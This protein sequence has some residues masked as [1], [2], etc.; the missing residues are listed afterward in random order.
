MFEFGINLLTVSVAFDVVLLVVGLGNVTLY[1][2]LTPDKDQSFAEIRSSERDYRSIVWPG[3]AALLTGLLI[4]LSSAFIFENLTSGDSSRFPTGELLFLAACITFALLL[5][6]V[7]KGEPRL[8][9][10]AQYP[11]RILAAAKGVSGDERDVAAIVETLQNR[12]ADW[13]RRCGAFSMGWTNITASPT[14]N[15]ALADVPGVSTLPLR[16][17]FRAIRRRGALRAALRTAPWRFGWPLYALLAAHLGAAVCL[18]ASDADTAPTVRLLL[19]IAAASAGCLFAAATGR[20]L[21]GTRRL[22]IGRSFLNS[23]R[24]ELDAA[25]RRARAAE[26]TKQAVAALPAQVAALREEV[27]IFPRTSS[28]ITILVGALVA[29]CGYAVGRLSRRSRSGG[30]E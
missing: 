10:Y 3:L 30:S 20:L 1:W 28:S 11:Q 12:L 22:A 14:L 7:L 17:A 18:L 23:C 9:Q 6:P 21:A 2:T 26:A 4:S 5:R 8:E 19:F 29:M 15:T 24:E 25:H 27:A 13:E 16:A